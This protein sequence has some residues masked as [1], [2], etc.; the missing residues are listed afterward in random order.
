MS[1]PA[2]ALSEIRDYLAHERESKAVSLTVGGPNGPASATGVGWLAFAPWDRSFYVAEE[3]SSVEVIPAGESSPTAIVPVGSGPF[4]VAVDAATEEV[5]VSNTASDNVTVINGSTDRVVANVAVLD[6]PMGLA[7][8]ASNRTVYVADNRSN[9][10]TVIS[11]PSLTVTTNISV[12]TSPTGVAWDPGSDRIFVSDWGSS[13]I[14]VLSGATERVV[15]N[16]AV[17]SEPYGIAD[18]NT[19]GNL[20]VANEGSNNVSVVSASTASLNATVPVAVTSFA[21]DLQDVAYDSVHH[22]VWVTAG[23]TVIVIAAA[24]ETATAEVTFDPSG[25]AFDPDNGSVCVTNSAN[26]SYGCFLYGASNIKSESNVTFSETGLPAGVSWAVTLTGRLHDS[27]TQMSAGSSIRFGVDSG[28]ISGDDEYGYAFTITASN[29][30]FPSPSNGNA[31]SYSAGPTSIPVAFSPSPLTFPVATVDVGKDPDSVAYDAANGYVYV[32]NNDSDNVTVLKGADAVGA[33][34]VGSG[35]GALT[36]DPRNGDIYVPDAGGDTVNVLNGTTLIANLTV[37]DRPLDS[38]YD[39]SNGFVYVSN[40]GSDNVSVLNG[41]AVVTAVPTGDGPM[42]LTFD[43]AHGFVDVVDT[44]DQTPDVTVLDGTTVAATVKMTGD[45]WSSAYDASNGDVY[46]AGIDGI[47]TSTVLLVTVLDGTSVASTLDAAASTNAQ[48]YV[49]YDPADGEIYASSVSS[50]NLTVINGTGVVG[51][52]PVSLGTSPGVYDPEDE[53]LYVPEAGALSVAIVSGPF[54]LEGVPVG[55]CPDSAVFAATN[56][57]VYVANGCSDNVSVL[58]SPIASYPVTFTESGLPT[59]TGWAVSLGSAEGR[60]TSS[61]IAFWE[62]NGTYSYEIG[63]AIGARATPS[64]GSIEVN[65]TGQTISIRFNSSGGGPTYLVNFTETGLAAG[66]SW[67]VDLNG[68]TSNSSGTEIAFS[69]PNGTYAFT[70][71]APSGATANPSAGS[72]TVD[73]ADRTISVTFSVGAAPPTYF[74]NFTESG[75]SSGAS[76]GV[77]LN[78]TSRNS[79]SSTIG[80]TERNGSYAFTA[81]CGGGEIASPASG[82]TNVSG[83]NVTTSVTCR[84]STS[85]LV[86]LMFRASGLSAG[87]NWSITLTGLAAGLTI[88][89]GAT[90]TRSSAG[91]ATVTFEVSDGSYDYQSA[92]RGEQAPGGAVTVRGTAPVTIVVSFAPAAGPHPSPISLPAGEEGVLGGALVA[93]GAAVVAWAG[94]RARAREREKGK[95]LVEWLS[96]PDWASNPPEDVEPRSGR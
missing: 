68:T 45:P 16:V 89:A 34:D 72:V 19:T 12:G 42:S 62:P 24:V 93:I 14:S 78:G 7:V 96:H 52:V 49:T 76:W 39:P 50:T 73:D 80:F 60:T 82:W 66:T 33:V 64:F 36:Y 67:D 79:T 6:D 18:D 87:T 94:T 2:S 65:G 86:P 75:L 27:V 56:G 29:G 17:G 40:F 53:Y 74:D 13:E 69:E 51:E 25:V 47:G 5:F 83:S 37:G 43:A 92:A 81:A 48:D 44:A 90:L 30:Y 15:A 63:S 46:V 10:V 85:G 20:Y 4:D 28:A 57:A 41:T 77:D 3:P 1:S 95:A 55:R 35:P 11:V 70:V 59:G 8:D 21:E 61:D 26:V 22:M 23:L 54:N 88:A 58:S 9:E 84:N 38:L 71:G 31:T 91:A 32:A